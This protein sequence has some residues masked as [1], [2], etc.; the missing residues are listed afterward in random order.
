[1]GLKFQVAVPPPTA[2]D[3]VK[4]ELLVKIQGGEPILVV[5]EPGQVVVSD[6]RFV[7]SDGS[8]VELAYTL[9]DDAGNRSIPR[10][11]VVQLLDTIAPSQP[12]ELS[13]SVTEEFA[14]PL[15]PAPESEVDSDSEVNSEQPAETED[16]PAPE[17]TE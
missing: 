1:M 15:P 3:V 16:L 2:S 5:T 8:T 6:D 9:I 4:G 17:A 7:G 11:A 13:L 12:G 14:D 10:E